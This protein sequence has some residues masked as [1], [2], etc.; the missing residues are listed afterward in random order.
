[1]EIAYNSI[2]SFMQSLFGVYSPVGYED[3]TG[4]FIVASGFAGVDWPYILGVCLFCLIV[5]CLFRLLGG[6]IWK[7]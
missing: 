5:Y 1:M 6:L 2:A 7:S 3:A 4:T